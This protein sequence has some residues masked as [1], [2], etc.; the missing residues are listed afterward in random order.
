M[1]KS[2]LFFLGVFAVL[3]LGAILIVAGSFKRFKEVCIS[4]LCIQ[5]E[6]AA[7]EKTREKGLMFR[8]S[9]PED[10]GMLFVFEKEDFHNFWMKNTRFPLDIVWIDS[11]KKIVDIY[12]YALPCKDV[13]KTIAPQAEAHFVLEVNAGFTKKHGIKIGDALSF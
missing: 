1:K 10:K 4:D 11:N 3:S 7:T 5:A 13:C 8:K 6:V 2:P 9:M 12:E